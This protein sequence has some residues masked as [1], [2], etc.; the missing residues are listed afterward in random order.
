M[1]Y[2]VVPSQFF[3]A[4]RF[5][6]FDLSR[7]VPCYMCTTIANTFHS[8]LLFCFILLYF[9]YK[10]IFCPSIMEHSKS[11]W[12]TQVQFEEYLRSSVFFFVHRC[13]THKH[14]VNGIRILMEMV[15]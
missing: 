2:F 12:E 9:L 14:S 5:T 6:I 8:V 3:C 7:H 4:F 10:K 11:I 13:I 15:L 1:F